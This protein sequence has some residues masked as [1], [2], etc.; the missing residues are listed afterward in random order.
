VFV[1][2]FELLCVTVTEELFDDEASPVDI[3]L[4]PA[5]FDDDELFDAVAE[6]PLPPVA[7]ASPP[8]ASA[9][10][11]PPLAE[12]VD[13]WS[14]M[15]VCTG[16]LTWT[17]PPVFDSA[18][19]TTTT[20][21]VA[22]CWTL[23]VADAPPPELLLPAVAAPELSDV[24]VFVEVFD[25]VWAT[26]TLAPFDAE[27]FPVLMSLP[28]VSFDDDASFDASGRATVATEG[29]GD[30]GLEGSWLELRAHDGQGDGV[31]VPAIRARVRVLDGV[32]ELV[33]HVALLVAPGVG[34]GPLIDRDDAQ[35]ILHDVVVGDG[36]RCRLVR[37][38]LVTV[39]G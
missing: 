19:C 10:P 14:V 35:C 28:V 34:R 37:W 6:P 30:H 21:A 12:P 33:G 11:V 39:L 1:L 32:V 36:F 22:V 20:S 17:L 24:A 4:P 9:V 25:C 13:T 27:A 31:A 2:E 23:D 8:E 16:A 7:T 15:F 18:V 26:A 29:I 5:L 38:F 3:E